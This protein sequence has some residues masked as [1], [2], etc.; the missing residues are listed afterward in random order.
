MK[1]TATGVK[2]AKV[3]AKPYKLTDGHSLYLFVNGK[4]K[5]WRYDYAAGGKRKTLSLGVYPEV[6]LGEARKRHQQAR[7]NLANG[8]DPS[9]LKRTHKNN[10]QIDATNSFNVIASEWFDVKM[11]GK[12]KKHLDRCRNILDKDLG[13]AIGS[14]PITAIKAP[15]VLRA[16]RKIELRGVDASRARST[17][18][19][20]F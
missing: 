6:S 7:E 19:Q 11:A 9:L 14:Q 1:L 5:Y 13:P 15:D 8:I 17:A 18:S 3:K 10:Q 12:S 16:L 2:Q 4:G 20:I